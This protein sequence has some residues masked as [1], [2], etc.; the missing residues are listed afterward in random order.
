MRILRTSLGALLVASAAVG[1][2]ALFQPASA[3][4]PDFCPRVPVGPPWVADDSCRACWSQGADPVVCTIVCAGGPQEHEFYNQCLADCS[5][6][7]IL[8]ECRRTGG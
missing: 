3:E 4:P 2:L 8:G 1:T 6:Y 7:I 5:H